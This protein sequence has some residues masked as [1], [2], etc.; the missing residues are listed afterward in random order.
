ML[1]HQAM[2]WQIEN[3]LAEE[4][5]ALHDA[6]WIPLGPKVSEALA[7]LARRG[8]LSGNHGSS[9]D[10]RTPPGA[11]AERIAVFLGRKCADAASAR[12]E[13]QDN[14]SGA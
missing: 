9:M 8:V 5:S 1:S 7:Y 12:T 11:N 14:R 13:L 3:F 2:R 6:V 10:C 4:A